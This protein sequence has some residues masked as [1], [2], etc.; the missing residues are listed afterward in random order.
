MTRRLPKSYIWRAVLC[1]ALGLVLVIWPDFAARYAITILGTALLTIGIVMGAAY[2]ASRRR[3]GNYGVGFPAWALVC[4]IAGVVLIAMP[5]LFA[6]ILIVVLG[7]LLILAAVDQMAMLYQASRG[8]RR[9]P[10][11]TYIAPALIL[12]VGILIA[13]SPS[14]ALRGMLTVFGVAAIFYGVVDLADQYTVGRRIR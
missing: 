9:I 6:Q 11:W 14:G 3:T 7:L 2:Y 13:L 5:G 12:L 10:W 4:I 1:I 8:V